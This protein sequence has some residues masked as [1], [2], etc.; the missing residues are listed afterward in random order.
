MVVEICCFL[1]CYVIL[2]DDVIN[3]SCDP[4]LETLKVSYHLAKSGGHRHGG[5]GDMIFL[6]YYVIMKGQVIKKHLT[7]WA[8]TPQGKPPT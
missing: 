7:L 2:Q 5:C 1:T 3:G 8:E 6:I 4:L